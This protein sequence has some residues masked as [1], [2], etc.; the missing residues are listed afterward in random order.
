M[1]SLDQKV[2]TIGEQL[3]ADEVVEA[4]RTLPPRYRAVIALRYGA[5]LDYRNVGKAMGISEA[6]ASMAAKRGLTLLRT[7][8]SKEVP[9][10]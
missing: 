1:W 2:V 6:A 10:L 7:R 3:L 4:V 9:T 8:L 5:D